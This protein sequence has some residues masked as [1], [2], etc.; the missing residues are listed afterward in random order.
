MSN[1]IVR[2]N[3]LRQKKLKNIIKNKITAMEVYL[4]SWSFLEFRHKIS[5]KLD[6]KEKYGFDIRVQQEKNY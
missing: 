3:F 6:V 5:R 2:S 1:S 4:H